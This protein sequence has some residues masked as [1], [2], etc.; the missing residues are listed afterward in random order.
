[1]TVNTNGNAVQHDGITGS[2]HDGCCMTCAQRIRRIEDALEGVENS[3]Q[4]L[5]DMV[6]E[7]R[8]SQLRTEK[9]VTDFMTAM[10][11]NPMLRAMGAKFGL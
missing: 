7:V 9:M 3:V 8:E 4:A 2:L 1:M 11:N 5:R 10:Q 6:Q